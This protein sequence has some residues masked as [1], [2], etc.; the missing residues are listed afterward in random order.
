MKDTN[1]KKGILKGH[2]KR[3][4]LKLNLKLKRMGMG[5]RKGKRRIFFS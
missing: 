2:M 1:S 3:L 4:K 5:G